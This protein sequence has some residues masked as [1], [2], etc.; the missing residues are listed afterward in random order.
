M[1]VAQA[2]ALLD[3]LPPEMLLCI[4]CRHDTMD[5]RAVVSLTTARIVGKDMDMGSREHTAM[6]VAVLA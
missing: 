1:T 2:A 6:E 5:I 3:A 4:A